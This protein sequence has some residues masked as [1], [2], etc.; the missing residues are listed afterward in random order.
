MAIT[1]AELLVSIGADTRGLDTGLSSATK[2]I[3][4]L[5]T[6]LGGVALG[7]MAL[8]AGGAVAAGAGLLSTISPASDLSETVSKIGIVFGKSATKVLNFG[9]T[10]AT[11]L[12]MSNNEA[13]AAAGTYGNLF[14]SM[15][16]G[17]GVSTDM[18][19]G[20]VKL[21]AD[22]ASFNNIDPSVAL[23]KLRAGLSGETEPLRTLGVNLNEAII[24]QKAFEMGLYSGEGALSASAKAQASYALILKQTGLAQGDF[25]RTSEGLANQQRIT[26]A[27][28]ENIKTTIGTALLPVMVELSN[29]F[30]DLLASAPV[31]EFLKNFVTILGD[32]T[33]KAVEFIS[34]VDWG[35]FFA[36]IQ[37]GWNVV[38]PILDEAWEVIKKVWDIV[39][40]GLQPS[41]IEAIMGIFT[42]L[43]ADIAAWASTVD[44]QGLIDSFNAKLIELTD[45]FTTWGTD[46]DF[47]PV[48]NS[49]GLGVGEGLKAA[50]KLAV[51][52]LGSWF[53]QGGLQTALKIPETIAS[54]NAEL[55]TGLV[56]GFIKGIT[57]WDISPDISKWLVDSIT[58]ALLMSNPATMVL[59]ALKNALSG[60]SLFFEIRGGE[61]QKPSGGGQRGNPLPPPAEKKEKSLYGYAS[62]GSVFG[63][64][65]IL[66]GERGP[67]LFVPRGAGTI[68]PTHKLGGGTVVNI[69]GIT[70]TGNA[71]ARVVEEAARESFLRAARSYGMSAA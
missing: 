32:L 4:G 40:D 43:G 67:E 71:D 3:S 62:G 36:Q 30:N 64:R 34:S 51:A 7:G 61:E 70:I 8:L 39:K 63:G 10:S 27:N 65:Q 33:L 60:F 68:V 2:S 15:E 69:G 46:T 17:E 29:K 66:V 47:Q 14:R 55:V 52:E 42:T 58:N 41:D 25:T 6:V 31:Q 18:S 16:I 26:A 54:I 50:F 44:W 37:N 57:G 22:L 20:L 49:I 35:A 53:S 48:G 11:A 23:D 28:F 9:K 56:T 59:T 24:K 45:Q 38:K 12:G 21:A 1:A 19:I 5:G 13:L